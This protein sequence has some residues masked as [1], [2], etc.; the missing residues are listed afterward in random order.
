MEKFCRDMPKIELHAH[1]NGSVSEQT[2]EK[3]LKRRAATSS[4]SSEQHGE[5]VAT[6]CNIKPGNDLSLDDCF[7]KFSII[8]QLCSDDESVYIITK[9]VIQEFAADNVKYLELRTGP[10]CNSTSNMTKSSYLKSVLQA[11]R[12]AT[13][14]KTSEI[15]VKL[16]ISIDRAKPLQEAWENLQLAKQFR[17]FD[18]GREDMGDV[19]VGLDLS[20]HPSTTDVEKFIPVLQAAR[21]SSFKLTIHV[22]EI[23]GREDECRKLISLRPHR[24]GH[25][26]NLSTH[27]NQCID[28]IQKILIQNI[29]LEICLTSNLMTSTIADLSSHH[30][31]YWLDKKHQCIICTDDKGMFSTSLSKEFILAST[32]FN[33]S[34]EE[35]WSMSRNAVEHIFSSEHVKEQLRTM[36]ATFICD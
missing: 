15:I 2:I 27:P 13:T 18:V 21:E 31:Q 14:V 30:L 19:I 11:I 8:H 5:A 25:A 20:G 33:L 23:A 9:D 28:I 16:I 26:T 7:K 34:K 36:F 22:S 32:T 29:P 6:G 24:L 17:N 35:V 4:S 3:L 10:K 12:D 1:L